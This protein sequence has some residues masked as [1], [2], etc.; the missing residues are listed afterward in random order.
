M[1]IPYHNY[2]FDDPNVDYEDLLHKFHVNPD[3]MRYELHRVW[4]A[5]ANL[6]EGKR[7]LY[8][9]RR[10]YV[11]EDTGLTVITENY[12]GRGELWKVVLINTL[13]EYETLAYIRR[14]QMYHD[15]RAGAYI[16][17]RLIN[18]SKPFLFDVEEAKGPGYFQPTNVRKLG[19]R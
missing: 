4:I 1:Y 9:K 8:G 14:A 11:D 16:A 13:Y 3:H 18:D 5:E 2:K 19:R 10:L 15:L 7:H 17:E 6:K 12:D